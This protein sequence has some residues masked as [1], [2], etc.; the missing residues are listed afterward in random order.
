MMGERP[1]YVRPPDRRFAAADGTD[2]LTTEE[3]GMLLDPAAR[4]DTA[5]G[6]YRRG[7]S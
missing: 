6:N 2:A 7:E 5:T 4:L 3:A 1:A